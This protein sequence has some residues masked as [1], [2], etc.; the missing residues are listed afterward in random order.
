VTR[1]SQPVTP[2]RCGPVHPAF[3]MAAEITDK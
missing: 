1:L 2:V 3:Q